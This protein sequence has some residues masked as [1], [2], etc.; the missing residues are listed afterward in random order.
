M[1]SEVCRSGRSHMLTATNTTPVG[2]GPRPRPDTSC[3]RADSNG[4]ASCWRISTPRSSTS[5]SSRSRSLSSEVTVGR[6]STSLT[7][8]SLDAPWDRSSSTSRP[9]V[10][11]SVKRHASSRNSWACCV[12]SSVGSTRFGQGHRPHCS[13]TSSGC[14]PTATLSGAERVL[15]AP[16]RSV[17]SPSELGRS[18][19][20]R[21]SPR[22]QGWRSPGSGDVPGVEPPAHHGP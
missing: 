15:R 2:T 18:G 4:G 3:T 21:N 19:T 11:R 17:I 7:S 16:Q 20:L 13:Q 10:G 22:Q 14:L 6:G 1:C 8:S 5:E 12:P 9:R